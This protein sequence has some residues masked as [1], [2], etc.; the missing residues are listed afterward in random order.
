[1]T[2]VPSGFFWV[3]KGLLAPPCPARHPRAGIWGPLEIGL[4]PAL[5]I[6]S[7]GWQQGPMDHSH[8]LAAP[9]RF[10]ATFCQR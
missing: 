5:L 10:L 3:K 2:I 9:G 1:M 6:A 7:H 8:T 4:M